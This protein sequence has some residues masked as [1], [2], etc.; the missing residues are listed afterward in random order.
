MIE[1]V[2]WHLF[3][4]TNPTRM[5]SPTFELLFSLNKSIL[6]LQQEKKTLMVQPATNLGKIG[7]QKSSMY[8]SRESSPKPSI[9]Q[10]T[11]A[12]TRLSSITFSP[13][14]RNRSFDQLAYADRNIFGAP[15]SSST[16]KSTLRFNFTSTKVPGIYFDAKFKEITNLFNDPLP[17]TDYFDLNTILMKY[18]MLQE[19]R[20][21]PILQQWEKVLTEIRDEFVK[22][23]KAKDD[24]LADK[25]YSIFGVSKGSSVVYFRLKDQYVSLS[26]SISCSHLH[27]DSVVLR[28]QNFCNLLHSCFELVKNPPITPYPTELL[29]ILD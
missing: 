16:E 8:K 11:Y 20:C 2:T 23:K 24:P 7:K 19:D 12:V 10:V 15:Q 28:V 27:Y 9:S 5:M 13:Q 17:T 6:E 26:F 4:R 22:I 1:T 18:T 14:E 25:I 29:P 3:D 21:L